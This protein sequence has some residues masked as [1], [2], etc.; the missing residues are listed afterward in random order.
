[1]IILTLGVCS[2]LRT[3][4]VNGHFISPFGALPRLRRPLRECVGLF[5]RSLSNLHGM[6]F[7]RA[8]LSI[9]SVFSGMWLILLHKLVNV[10]WS[11]KMI[12]S[13]KYETF[14]NR[15]C[16]LHLIP[17]QKKKHVKQHIKWQQLREWNRKWNNEWCQ[18]EMQQF[19]NSP[20]KTKRQ[21]YR[22]SRS[23]T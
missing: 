19:W 21:Q 3:A 23:E 5:F 11:S 22:K 6:R 9:N 18:G 20:S 10:F 12:Q 16:R 8:D 4:A 14:I 15:V 17:H 2:W 1:M 13:S 7:T